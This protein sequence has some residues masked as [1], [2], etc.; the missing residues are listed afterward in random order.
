VSEDVYH[1][2]AKVLD[3]LPNGFPTTESGVEIKLLRKVFTPEE[4]D[5][6]CDLRLTPETA[7]QIAARAGRPLEGLEE[8]LKN[9]SARG[10]VRGM[11]VQGKLHFAMLPWILGIYEY[12]LGRLDREF[13]LLNDEY[14]P[15]F[16]RQFFE[17]KPQLM[18]VLPVERDLP[19]TAEIMP[20]ER[21]SNI[22]D[23]GKSFS[24]GECIC[25]KEQRI[26]GKGC[27]KPLEACMA[28]SPVAGTFE[29]SGR[30][31][32]VSQEEAYELLKSFEEA[33]L[34]HQ[35]SNTRT[36][37]FYI[38]NC[39]G[40]CCGV[41][42]GYNKL[43]ITDSSNSAY[44]AEID[45]DLCT[46]CG[47]CADE[48]CQV[49]AIEEGD[50]AYRVIQERCIGCGLCV[51]TCPGEAIRLVRKPDDKIATPPETQAEWNELRGRIRGVDF[52]QYK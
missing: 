39:C 34:V 47:T 1:R 7:E 51:S 52:S 49:R 3:T 13:A 16:I 23:K 25:R 37:Q 9:M 33:G 35:A 15:V 2:L 21:V 12:Q 5:L 14:H 41:L 17:T 31:R 10:E 50:A 19:N 43:G 4:A 28:V 24:V 48:R 44:Y 46:A 29:A 6:F 40:C 27:D 20:Y 8:R 45:P 11:P 18:Q 32:V 36:G 22:I 38:C 30:G 42:D 26:L